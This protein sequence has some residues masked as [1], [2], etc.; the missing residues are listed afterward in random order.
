MTPEQQAMVEQYRYVPAWLVCVRIGVDSNIVQ[1]GVRRFGSTDD[2]IAEL[3]LEVIRAAKAYQSDRGAT[4]QTWITRLVWQRLINLCKLPKKLIFA[5]NFSDHQEYYILDH[6]DPETYMSD[7]S[8]PKIDLSGLCDRQ[9]MV[10]ISRFGLHDGRPK[11]LH[12]VGEMLGV[13]KERVRQIQNQA[14][15][16]LRETQFVDGPP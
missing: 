5:Q 10:L 12:V 15:K 8:K 13:S 3:Q 7:N 2:L 16:Y 11:P 6:A 1:C 14:L 9:R 4:I